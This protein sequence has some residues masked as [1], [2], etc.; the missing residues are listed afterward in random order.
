MS[1]LDSLGSALGGIAQI[2]LPIAQQYL[3]AELARK[4]QRQAF[5]ATAGPYMMKTA[6]APPAPPSSGGSVP[7]EYKTPRG[8]VKYPANPWT[9][10][11]HAY[12]HQQGLVPMYRRK[13][14]RTNFTNYKALS[15]ALRRVEG[16]ARTVKRVKQST[17]K[18][19][20]LT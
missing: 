2:G 9:A 17:R 18:M 5:S 1:F 10:N 12:Y 19:K 11:V 4:Q 16:F 8:T 3:G 7:S 20:A 15:R 14:R 6:V 13:R